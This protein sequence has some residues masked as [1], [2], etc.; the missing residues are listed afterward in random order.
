QALNVQLASLK[1]SQTDAA[2]SAKQLA[3]A[4]EEVAYSTTEARGAAKLLGEEAGVNLNRHLAN[5]VANSKVL[6]PLLEA[7]FPVAAVIGFYEVISNAA[8]KLSSFIADTF[9]F[10]DEMKEIDK[11]GAAAN[12]TIAASAQ[13]I[14]ELQKA[15]ALIGL[16]GSA[17]DIAQLQEL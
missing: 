11:A 9:I 2:A 15:Y 14:Q 7:A 3:N 6:G 4:E 8:E 13:R 12:A 17:K 5:V 1:K 10:T 16:S